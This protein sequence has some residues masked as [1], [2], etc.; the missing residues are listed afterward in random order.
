MGLRRPEKAWD[1]TAGNKNW[2]HDPN[3]QLLT[4]T[5]CLRLIFF[6]T[7]YKKP[8]IG[9]LS[10]VVDLFIYL[11]GVLCR[12]Q[13]CT[14]HITMGSWK[15][16]GNQNIQ[17]VRVLYCKLPTNDKQFPAFPLQGM[18]GI[19]SQ[20]QRWEARVLPLCHCGPQ[21]C[22]GTPTLTSVNRQILITLYHNS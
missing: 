15:G 22:G 13:H 3:Q 7:D 18:M 1:W 21:S 20:S 6:E 9:K 8:L 4:H 10:H 12:F 5:E 16:R 14:G 17:F 11:F 2:S 19:E